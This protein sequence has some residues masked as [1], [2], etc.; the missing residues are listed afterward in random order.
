[1]LP[2]KTVKRNLKIYPPLN[3][4]NI[5]LW[6]LLFQPR[7]MKAK[8]NSWY[9]IY[10]DF[11]QRNYRQF[12]QAILHLQRKYLCYSK[13]LGAGIL[14]AELYNFFTFPQKKKTVEIHIWTI[15]RLH[16]SS[17]SYTPICPK[18]NVCFRNTCFSEMNFGTYI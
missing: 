4:D 9:K 8:L 10:Y 2:L 1:M 18:P 14:L 17:E 7:I 11:P 13:A 5:N 15:A 12:V 3:N 16:R 6:F